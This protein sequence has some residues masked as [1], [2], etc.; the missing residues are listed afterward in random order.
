MA[1]RVLGLSDVHHQCEPVPRLAHSPPEDRRHMEQEGVNLAEATLNPPR[2]LHSGREQSKLRS[3][4]TPA[5]TRL[6]HLSANAGA[7]VC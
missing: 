1:I 4:E 3:E 6:D 7:P 5:G 2:T